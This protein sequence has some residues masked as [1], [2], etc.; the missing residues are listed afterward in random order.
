[1]ARGWR[2]LWLGPSAELRAGNRQHSL[3]PG[4]EKAGFIITFSSLSDG[5][6]ELSKGSGQLPACGRR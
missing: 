6:K 1:M 4:K 5:Q 3:C 2:N